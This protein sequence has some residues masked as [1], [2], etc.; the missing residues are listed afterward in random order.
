VIS[1]GV[2]LLALYFCYTASSIIKEGIT[3]ED[4]IGWVTKRC[5]FFIPFATHLWLL[6]LCGCAS[7]YG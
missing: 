2:V 5:L 6:R 3:A 4:A 1:F 7:E